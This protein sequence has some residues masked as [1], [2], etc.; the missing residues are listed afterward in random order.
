MTQVDISTSS[1]SCTFPASVR[2]LRLDSGG[3]DSI[4][5]GT[6]SSIVLDVFILVACGVCSPL[7]V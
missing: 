1:R 3:T 4:G 7:S 5:T 6:I 2:L